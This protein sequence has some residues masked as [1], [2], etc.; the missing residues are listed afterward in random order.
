MPSFSGLLTKL[1]G[2]GFYYTRNPRH[3]SYNFN[4]ES[5]ALY[6]NQPRFPFEYYI[7]TNLTFSLYILCSFNNIGRNRI[8][9]LV[10]DYNSYKIKDRGC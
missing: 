4:Q 6:R 2:A 5:N 7:D 9:L 10:W 1:T 8:N 3:A